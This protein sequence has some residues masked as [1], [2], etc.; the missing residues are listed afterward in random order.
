VPLKSKKAMKLTSGYLVEPNSRRIDEDGVTID[1][2]VGMNSISTDL[3][4][5]AAVL[6]AYT[7]LKI[8]HRQEAN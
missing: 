2:V 4:Q 7:E 1:I 8:Q 3:E 6:K 5:D